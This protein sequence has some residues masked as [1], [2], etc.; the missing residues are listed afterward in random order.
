MQL[1]SVVLP[2]PFGPMSP[3]MR[4]GATSKETRLS[5]TMP[6]KRTATSCT[7]RSACPASAAK[8]P[9]PFINFTELESD[10]LRDPSMSEVASYTVRDGVAVITMNNPPVN[11][12]GNALRAGILQGLQRADEDP[13][14]KAVVLIGGGKAFSGGADIREF[15]KPREKPDLP[16]VNDYQDSMKKPLVAAISGFALG[17]GL[18][19]ALACHYRIATPKAQLGLPEVKLGILPGSG[20]TQRLPRIVPVA[21]A[22]EMMTS[23]TPVSSEQALQLGL[24][25]EIVQNSD[26]LDAAV[27]YANQLV[28]E[29]KPLKRIRDLSARVD[30]DPK[31][32]FA[33]VRDKVAKESRGYPAPLEIVACVEA[34]VTRP[35]DEGR[36]FE[37]ERFAHLVVTSESKALRHAFFAERQTSKIPDVPEDTPARAI[38]KAAV[39]GAGTMGGGIAMSFA[40]VGIPVTLT[41]TTREALERGLQRIRENYAG[42]VQKGRLKQEEM[43]QRMALLQPTTDL[44]SVRDADIVVE[45][46]FERMDVK[47]ELFR[48]L[49][50]IAKPGAILA[51]NT[52]TLDV[53]QIA[54]AT[55][56]PQ[57]VVGTHFFS[58]AN[59]MRLLEVVRGKQ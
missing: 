24:V 43:D 26:L 32:F 40:N 46:V 29:R 5:A 10:T 2:A 50:G 3:T 9:P 44:G 48:K 45:A 18:E 15:G 36:Q 19:L 51:T 6:A 35:F 16:D 30:G 38:K 57:D 59:V 7:R 27:V 47:Q 28:A 55:Q 12:L 58:P 34:A 37:R 8:G 56:R 42:T 52:S 21:K 53:N 49:D 17:G 33:G 14:V 23:G 11:G 20:G 1:K 25:D 39:I 4:P 54:A 22:I 13:A 41:D 31:A